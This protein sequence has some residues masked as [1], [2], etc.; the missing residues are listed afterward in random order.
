MRYLP[1]LLLL[2]LVGCADATDPV[3]NVSER[4]WLDT[5]LTY[6]SVVDVEGNVYPTITIGG[7]EWMVENLR[8][9]K[10]Q[11]GD[12]IPQLDSSGLVGASAGGWSHYMNDTTTD[13]P[14][15]LLYNGYTVRDPRNVC[16]AGWH[17]PTDSE[18]GELELAVGLKKWELD[19][20]GIRGEHD[21]V[22]SLL[23][24]VNY[25]DTA[26]VDVPGTNQFGFSG[27]PA[28]TFNRYSGYYGRGET[29]TW[30]TSNEQG[31]DSVLTRTLTIPVYYW[32]D[33][34]VGDMQMVVSDRVGIIREVISK[35]A[36]L[37][38]RCVKDQPT[39][40][41]RAWDLNPSDERSANTQKFVG[42]LLVEQQP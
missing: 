39:N 29:G 41:P 19:Q 31:A 1:P 37:S 26:I 23:K 25:W 2:L 28:G 42:E 11:N 35:N 9:T 3:I 36:G 38:I 30:W 17:V 16:P 40:G 20:F 34:V 12:R 32:E 4:P 7:R 33:P 24:T 18:W 21:D 15:G 5:A 22:G 13:L 14:Y 27:L 8:T 6:N 10:Y